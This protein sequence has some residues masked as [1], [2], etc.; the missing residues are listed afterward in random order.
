MPNV[1]PSLA[2]QFFDYF[3]SLP[4]ADQ[5]RRLHA[6][7]N[8]TPPTFETEWLDFKG[9]PQAQ[10]IGDIWSS[11]VSGF[12]NTGGGVLIWGIDAR[13]DA[14]GVDCAAGMRLVDQPASFRQRLI[15]L[16][17][18]LADP[19]VLGVDLIPLDDAAV[20][21][22][23]FVICLIPESTFKPHRALRCKNKPY[24]IRVVDRF[25]VAPHSLL[26]TLF[27]PV[28]NPRFAV[29]VDAV[30]GGWQADNQGVA[31]TMDIVFA[32]RVSNSG[33]ATARD[34]FV[35]MEVDQLGEIH[36]RESIPTDA[37]VRRNGTLFVGAEARRPLHP[38]SEL[39]L[40]QFHRRV[41]CANGEPVY[42]FHHVRFDFSLFALDC[43]EQR[44]IVALTLDPAT[45]TASGS[46]VASLA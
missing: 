15:D 28:S 42:D 25:E 9:M 32:V 34:L 3:R 2:Q 36:H 19:P 6:M 5:L 35:R 27:Y 46:T 29:R 24:Y 45:G 41:T 44:A 1:V 11:S 43:E 10:D 21:G 14:S 16:S 18:D 22:K 8:S 23:G 13:R 20:P 26:R 38:G 37:H 40:L 4:Q 12:A 31:Q 7:V 30:R 39:V 33:T 17:Q